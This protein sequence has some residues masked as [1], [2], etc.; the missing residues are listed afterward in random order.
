VPHDA[1]VH[2]DYASKI[3]SHVFIHFEASEFNH[4]VL[5]VANIIQ[6]TRPHVE[7]QSVL[8]WNLVKV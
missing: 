5:I 1:A 8:L 2:T 6:V 3:N 7:I 4:S